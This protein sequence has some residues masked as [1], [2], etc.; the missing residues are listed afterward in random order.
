LVLVNSLSIEASCQRVSE[1]SAFKAKPEGRPE[2]R[3]DLPG[4]ELWGQLPMKQSGE[5]AWSGGW[6]CGWRSW[7]LV[8]L[9][10]WLVGW[11]TVFV[12]EAGGFSIVGW[13]DL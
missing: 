6:Q 13:D 10:G 3:S 5:W 9:V 2:E 11:L 12:R 1:C 8:W 7:L 4:E